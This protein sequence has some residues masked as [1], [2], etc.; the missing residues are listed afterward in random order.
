MDAS[1]TVNQSETSK[2]RALSK[3]ERAVVYAKT[4]GLCHICGGEL[5]KSWNADHV[6]PFSVGGGSEIDNFLPACRTCNRLKWNWDPENIRRMMK[7]GTIAAQEI[8]L[9][10][11]TG[12]NIAR[13][14]NRNE[15]KN[16]ARKK[17]S[18]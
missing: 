2:R 15:A 5:G 12:R 8:K 17:P 13:I 14:Y 9:D 1:G 3:K 18:L 11:E 6:K 7:L 16:A 10:T 4:G